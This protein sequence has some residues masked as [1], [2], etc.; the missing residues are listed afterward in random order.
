MWTPIIALASALVL[1]AS[2]NTQSGAIPD[3][4]FDPRSYQ[5]EVRG[6][7]SQV[8]VLGTPHLA[9][10]EGFDPAS[11]DALLDHLESF[12]PDVIAIEALPGQTLY[13]MSG[14]DE[15]FGGTAAMFGRA[16]LEA[17]RIAGANLELDMPAAAVA[18]EAR[19]AGWPA[20]PTEQDRRA[21]AALFAASGDPFSALVQWLRLDPAARVPGEGVDEALI[22]VF[23]RVAQSHNEN[24]TI[25]VA[26]AVRLGLERIYL[27]DDQTAQLV[28]RRIMDDLVAGLEAPENAGIQVRE[29]LADWLMTSDDWRDGEALLAFYRRLNSPQAGHVDADAQWLRFLNRNFPQAAGRARMADWETRN[30][31][32]AAHVR[33]ASGDAPGGRVLV[34]TGSAHKPWLDAYL[35]M[36]TD[37][38]IV[39]AVEVLG[40]ES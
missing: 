37:V 13:L 20:E 32:M 33:E 24:V 27:T 4:P 3:T 40:D 8:Y 35:E 21:L 11:L 23:D 17:S 14:Y 34:V 22:A 26:L 12:G 16:A 30:L 38:R 28:S 18:L 36:M 5:S 39:P 29:L 10:T 25:A 19:L 9:Q 1:A 7:L 2:A 15:L 6:E 31:R